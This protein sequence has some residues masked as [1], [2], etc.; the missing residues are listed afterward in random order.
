MQL[1]R[2]GL[3][4]R[5]LAI[6][7]SLV[8]LVIM[9]AGT[10]SWLVPPANL[11]GVYVLSVALGLLLV[12][13]LTSWRMLGRSLFDP[14]VL[15][16]VSAFLFNAGQPLLEILN[17]TSNGILGGNFSDAT[18]QS[19][20]ILV[21]AGLAGLH[22][23][24]ILAIAW[25]RG[26]NRPA[27]FD[28]RR[29]SLRTVGWISLFVSLPAAAIWL[30]QS[31]AIVS[32]SG[33][34]SLYDRNFSAGLS[35]TPLL[36]TNLLITGSLFLTAGGPG[37]VGEAR[38]ACAVVVTFALIQFYMGYRSTAA[39]PLIAW[40]WLWHRTVKP[41]R[42]SALLG[43]AAALILVVFP[44]VRETRNMSSAERSFESI[45]SSVMSLDNPAITSIEEMGQ[46]MST[47]AHTVELVP[48]ERAFDRGEGYAY[49]ALTLFPNLFWPIHPT[50]A[51]GTNNDWLVTTVNPWLSMRGGAYG[52]SP[53][54]EAYL[55]FGPA[56]TPVIMC[57]FGILLV[58]LILW[59]E[60]SPAPARLALVA[61]ILA[62]TLRF[63]R[64]EL[65]GILRPIVWY[66][67]MPYLA[68]VLGP[69][70]VRQTLKTRAVR[71]R[72]RATAAGS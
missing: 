36:L 4:N 55:N 27:P 71:L 40:A 56:G 44:V 47:V 7:L 24:A 29:V 2:P 28:P 67:L 66:G 31:V 35:S 57:L 1:L 22:L 5:T 26:E 19:T 53:I 10:S 52:Y 42:V 12:W 61:V 17:A 62:F 6:T 49:A 41:I 16:L 39:M 63:P 69:G 18:L 58:T 32:A 38:F 60:R 50:I 34:A 65:A 14:Y 59:A 45:T 68:A 48:A 72:Y 8:Q 20:L 43:S 70:V 30:S 3:S 64:D 21:F 13:S 37:R 23:G 11:P 25:R 54:A 33:Y 15:F 9:V 46:S 51:R